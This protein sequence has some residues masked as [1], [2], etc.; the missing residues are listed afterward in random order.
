MDSNLAKIAR[1]NSI[2]VAIL[3]FIA[4]MAL[5]GLLATL[6][7][8]RSLQTIFAIIAITLAVAL[9]IHQKRFSLYSIFLVVSGILFLLS[10][11]V[12][13]A[14]HTVV[15]PLPVLQQSEFSM[16]MRPRQ[17]SRG[18]WHIGIGILYMVFSFAAF[19]SKDAFIKPKSRRSKFVLLMM[20]VMG[21]LYSVFGITSII[22]GL[23]KL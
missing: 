5:V 17:V 12:D 4:M 22:E 11:A 1:R 20:A 9:P 19:Q 21:V 23:S 8:S 2:L 13:Y 10:G 16:I 7:P 15:S 18:L 3:I 14:Y 6:V